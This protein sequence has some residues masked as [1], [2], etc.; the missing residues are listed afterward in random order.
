M[1]GNGVRRYRAAV[2]GAGGIARGSHLPALA[3]HGDRVGVESI[4]DI[5][6]VR[7]AA[8]AAEW[9]VPHH[10]TDLSTML[11]ACRP[12][13][14]VVCT[15]PGQ[16]LPAI[17]ASLAAGAWVWCEKPP[18]LSLADY[19]R[20]ATGERSGGPYASFVFQHR[21]GSAARHVRGL[22]GAGALGRPL[23]AVCNT[24]WYR[25]QA[26]F[27][28]PWRGRWDTEGGGPT[29]GHGI[30]QFD[31][32]L[33]LLGDWAEVR[34]VARRLDRDVEAEDVSA[35]VVT[36]AS[37]AV[38]TVVNS[39]LSPREESYLRFDF[40]RATVEVS[41][42]YGYDNGD[43]RFTPRPGVGGGLWPP[44]ED[45]R[46]SHAVQLS[47]LL[48]AMDRGQRPAASGP[49]GRRSLELAAGIYQS[50]AT[51]MVVRRAE[52]VPGNPF[53]ERMRGAS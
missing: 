45:V 13:L 51:D 4:V 2:V 39:V 23:V 48:D 6:A 5:D 41:H 21:F 31:L 35:A 47:A 46:G 24:L 44:G 22:V 34:A 9:R 18:T 28:V 26:Y 27:D 10:G 33:H 15:P 11:A 49:D 7:A 12:E 53:Y 40:Q 25:D 37:G 14:V 43:W 16:H 29:M 8:V 42:L 52:L 38:V 50:S 3:A 36:M 17:E 30:H 32:M 19:D 1:T 20:A